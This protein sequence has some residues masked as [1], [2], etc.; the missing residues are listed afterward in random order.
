MSDD[1]KGYVGQ[2]LGLKFDGEHIVI[3]VQSADGRYADGYMTRDD[4]MAVTCTL[5]AMLEELGQGPKS[6]AVPAKC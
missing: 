3:R 2:A 4:A 5:L 6:R 1:S